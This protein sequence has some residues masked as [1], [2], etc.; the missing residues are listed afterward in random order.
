MD[1]RKG[2]HNPPL[3][4]GSKRPPNPLAQPTK[5]SI[6]DSIVT[7]II[8]PKGGK[9]ELYKAAPEMYEII[10]RY[11]LLLCRLKELPN[12]G[13]PG[14]CQ[15]DYYLMTNLICKIDKIGED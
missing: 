10:Q 3:V 2:G 13:I 8:I 14:P 1:M 5:P 9:E 4:L 12:K 6:H 11:F 7:T 15:K